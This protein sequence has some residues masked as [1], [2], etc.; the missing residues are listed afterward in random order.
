MACGFCLFCCSD[1]EEEHPRA[2]GREMTHFFVDARNVRACFD[3]F[4]PV[5]GRENL[6][7]SILM[8]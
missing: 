2:R 1:G 6:L 8:S 3:V 5:G 7:I 4:G